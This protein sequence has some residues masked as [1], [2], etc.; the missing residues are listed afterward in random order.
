MRQV[1]TS[2]PTEGLTFAYWLS[3]NEF[4]CMELLT[5]FEYSFEIQPPLF[6]ET[7]FRISNNHMNRRTMY[8]VL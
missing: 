2:S 5:Y 4:Y 7:I 1:K 3:E 6:T 8:C